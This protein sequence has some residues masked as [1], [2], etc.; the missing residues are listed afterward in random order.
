AVVLDVHGIAGYA[1]MVEQARGEV[2]ERIEGVAELI[3]RWSVGKPEAEVVGGD[4]VIAVG[5]RRDEVAEHE[6]TG[7]KPV[8]KHD[9]GR[10]AGPSLPVEQALPLNGGVAV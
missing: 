5:Q 7:R 1:E 6:G 3:G 9:R 8:Q 4:H 10:V 2:G